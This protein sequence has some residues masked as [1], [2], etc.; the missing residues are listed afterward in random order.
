MRRVPSTER[1]AAPRATERLAPDPA[2]TARAAELL[3]AGRLVAFPTETVYGLGADG[4][5]PTAVAAL[6]EAK[7]RPRFN[8]LIAHLPDTE[9]ARREG[10][11]DRDA[12]RL[13]RAFWPGP[14]T[15]VVPLGPAS[16][17]C[18]LARAGLGSVALRVPS[19]PLARAILLQA[20][21]PIVAPSANQS[22]RV[23]PTRAGH[24]LADLDGRIA[25]ILDGG[26]TEVGLESTIVA[27]L[28][29][30][31]RLLRPGGVAREAI[32]AAL[33]RPLAGP[34]TDP[35]R[36]LAPGGLLSHYAPR[37]RVRPGG[38]RLLP[39]EAALLFGPA[40]LAG[41]GEAAMILNL[42]PAGDMAEAAANL[43][44]HLRALDASGAPVIVVAPIPK[45]GLGEAINDR[46]ARAAA[47]R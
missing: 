26:P 46:L 4:T 43:F 12:E 8:P 17:V 39:G 41:S 47:A 35:G 42:S 13:A 19:H 11:L 25:A 34:D 20:A 30:T 45:H 38:D 28:E 31:P 15:L 22:G 44:G 9:G 2:G 27:C 16:R 33:G 29:G 1:P 36:P 3:A 24:V 21:R 40:G 6:Y 18:D 32:E 5:D 37:A 23:S 10:R 7:E 14:L